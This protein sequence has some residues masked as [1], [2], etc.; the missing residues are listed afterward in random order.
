[1]EK[2]Q[3]DEKRIFQQHFSMEGKV[4]KTGRVT[5]LIGVGIIFGMVLVVI[6]WVIPRVAADTSPGASPGS[7]VGSFWVNVIANV[8]CG[9]AMLGAIFLTRSGTSTALLV[10]AGV[11]LLLLGLF[12]LDGAF[13]FT[14][15][16]P[17]M[18]DVAAVLF[19]CVGGEGV[20][21]I[22][23]FVGAALLARSRKRELRAA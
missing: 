11:G 4:M 17:S 1:M 12:L 6:L 9:L 22:L 2:E 8:F 5:I 10:I 21:A 15:H 16:G 19:W 13:S 3:R 18:Q 20:A 7:A 23:A 14:T